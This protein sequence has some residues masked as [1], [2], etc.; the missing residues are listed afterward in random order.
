MSP[1]TTI[2]PFMNRL[3]SFLYLFLLLGAVTACSLPIGDTSESFPLAPTTLRQ[4]PDCAALPEQ[5]NPTIYRC[6]GTASPMF[7]TIVKDC[8]VSEKFSHRATT[9]QLL[10]GITN[11]KVL[12]Q[13]P[14]SLGGSKALRSVVEGSLDVDSVLISTFTVRHDS[15][16]TDLVVWQAS[17]EKPSAPL[18]ENIVRETITRETQI[19]MFQNA[20][21][22]LAQRVG[23]E[24]LGENFATPPS[25]ES[26][27]REAPVQGGSSALTGLST[28]SATD[29]L[30]VES[31]RPMVATPRDTSEG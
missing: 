4:I 5:R 28:R 6:T 26:V 23:I 24:G 30:V 7:I 25:D 27:P 21:T 15:C 22:L 9:R 31:N 3:F 1:T 29:L 17:G 20:S 18:S 10:V 11:L 14:V 12:N 2:Y 19:A 13:E 8:S 16:V